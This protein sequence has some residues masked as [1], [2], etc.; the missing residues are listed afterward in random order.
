MWFLT[1]FLQVPEPPKF[2]SSVSVNVSLHI[3]MHFLQFYSFETFNC[4][5]F[6]FVIFKYGGAS[7]NRHKVI[8][9]CNTSL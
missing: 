5:R 6:F 2:S 8:V 1:K 4:A 7:L 3:K 9:H